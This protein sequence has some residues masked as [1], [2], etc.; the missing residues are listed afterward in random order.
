MIALANLV[1]IDETSNG[2]IL[3]VVDG[4]VVLTGLFVFGMRPT[5]YAMLGI[6]VQTK[7]SDMIVEGFNYSKAAYII[8][9]EH[10]VVANRIMNELERGL[11][12]LQAKGMYTGEDKCVLYC[13]VS[14]KEIVRLKDIVNEE[15][16]HAFVI[17]SDVRE[18]LG[19]G[20]QE[21]KKEF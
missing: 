17:V 16:P 20:F 18:V 5:L 9:N 4:L 21:Y 10:E 6:V 2:K 14:Q 3:Q 8:T 15:D 11:T 13:I 19:E 7:V 1:Y 12:G